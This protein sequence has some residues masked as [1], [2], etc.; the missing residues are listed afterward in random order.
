MNDT[1]E[2][3]LETW[4]LREGTWRAYDV[5]R[6]GWLVYDLDTPGGTWAA[7]GTETG[8]AGYRAA[9]VA[10]EAKYAEEIKTYE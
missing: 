10:V 5:G 1:P 2:E 6:G 3:M 9:W 4:M 8:D 7:S